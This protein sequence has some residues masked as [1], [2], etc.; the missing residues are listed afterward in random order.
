MIAI[1]G[2]KQEMEIGE[3]N[4]GPGKIVQA[5]LLMLV[6][7]LKIVRQGLQGITSNLPPSSQELDPEIDLVG[8]TDVRSEIRRVVQCVVTD[9]IEPAIADLAAAARYQPS[10]A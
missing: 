2:A 10:R 1:E 6:A 7:L 5:L 4:A 9:F 3:P 8:E